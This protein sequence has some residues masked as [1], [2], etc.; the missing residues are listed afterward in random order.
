MEHW[1]L[2]GPVTPTCSWI[3]LNGIK[4]H[5]DP[6]SLQPGLFTE[7]QLDIAGGKIKT[8]WEGCSSPQQWRAETSY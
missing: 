5:S 8:V 1:V 4:L 6:L 3:P 7:R 2:N